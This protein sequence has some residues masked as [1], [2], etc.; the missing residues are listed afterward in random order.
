MHT[1][2]HCAISNDSQTFTRAVRQPMYCAS[3]AGKLVLLL[4][5]EN[6][7]KSISHIDYNPTRVLLS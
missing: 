1:I 4:K 6:E 5:Q 2:E 3:E 7:F